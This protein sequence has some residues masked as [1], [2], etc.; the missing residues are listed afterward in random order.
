MGRQ[1]SATTAGQPCHSQSIDLEPQQPVDD[2]RSGG[3][4]RGGAV[5]SGMLAGGGGVA[6]C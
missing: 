2:C 5:G 4:G 1:C 3:E 6:D